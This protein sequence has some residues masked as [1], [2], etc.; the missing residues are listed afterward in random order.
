[1]PDATLTRL[2]RPTNSRA[3]RRPDK[4]FTPHP[5]VVLGWAY[6]MHILGSQYYLLLR[7]SSATSTIISSWPPTIRRL[8]SSTRISTALKP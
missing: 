7:R 8:P 5:A 6:K 1:M 4:T 3:I 2:I